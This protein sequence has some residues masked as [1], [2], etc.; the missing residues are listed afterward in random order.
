[1]VHLRADAAHALQSGDHTHHLKNLVGRDAHSER[2]HVATRESGALILRE[3]GDVLGIVELAVAIEGDVAAPEGAHANQAAMLGSSRLDAPVDMERTAIRLDPRRNPAVDTRRLAERLDLER[4]VPASSV[5][6]TRYAL[7]DIGQKYIVFQPDEGG[8][9]LQLP[10]GTYAVEWFSL[11]D[12]SWTDGDAMSAQE[13]GTTAMRPPT[14]GPCVLHLA[15]T[16][17]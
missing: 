2:E 12:R 9:T 8:F 7:A 10:P 3:A 13:G 6:S 14:A 1:V 16:E 17:G 4:M 15:R 11:A 5:S